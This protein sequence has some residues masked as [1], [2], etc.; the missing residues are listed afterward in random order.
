[1]AKLHRGCTGGIITLVPSV[2]SLL[3]VLLLDPNRPKVIQW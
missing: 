3:D 2:V 1:M